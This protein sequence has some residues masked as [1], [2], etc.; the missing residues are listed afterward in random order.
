MQGASSGP[1]L[2]LVCWHSGNNIDPDNGD[3]AAGED[4]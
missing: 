2:V 1:E 3:E 4:S